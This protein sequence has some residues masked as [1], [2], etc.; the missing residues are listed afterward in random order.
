MLKA[1]GLHPITTASPKNFDLVKSFGAADVFDYT[2]DGT[3]ARIAASYP[4]LAAGLDTIAEKGTT[5]QAVLSFGEKGGHL[6]TLLPTKPE[7]QGGRPEVKVEATLVY[8]VSG[9]EVNFG[10][11][12]VIPAMPEDRTAIE[13]WLNYVPSLIESGGLRSNPLWSQ[14]GGLKAIPEGLALLREGKVSGQKVTYKL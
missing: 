3:P 4:D 12:W 9:K 5:A 14:S 2:D 1:S 10:P 11:S 6:I 8:S 7:Q 13:Q